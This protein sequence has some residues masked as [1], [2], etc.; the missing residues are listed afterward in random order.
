ME[1][2][3]I[4]SGLSGAV[5]ANKF[6]KKG[7]KVLVLEKRNHIAG[8]VYDKKISGVT[9]HMY[10]PHIFHTNN[11]EVNT[12]MKQFWTLNDFKNKVEGMVQDMI[13]PIPFNFTGVERFFIEEAE[14]IKAKLIDKY[15][16][17]NRVTIFELLSNNDEQLKKVANFVYKNIFE[18]YTTK[19]WG[20]HPNDIDQSV[21]KR[22]PIITG[23]GTRYF[24][25]KYEGVPTEGYTSAVQK[26]LDHKN[27][28]VKLNTNAVD[29][30]ELKDGKVFIDNVEIKCPII[31]TG[32]LDELFNFEY[33]EL[34]Y[35]S[36]KI[37]FEEEPVKK[38][39]STAVVNYPAH[40]KMT[41]ITE[42][43]NMTFEET[44][45]TIISKE[46]PGEYSR[47]SKDF[48]IPYYPMANDESRKQYDKYLKKLNEFKNIYPLGRLARYKYLN[49][50]QI[51]YDSLELTK[52]LLD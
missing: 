50:D 34:S 21:L 13:V 38:F 44:E 29:I 43:K 4:G 12:Y 33:G 52:Q 1:L 27:I 28:E 30:L 6:A 23:Y 36:L 2:L 14:E 32:A 25:D 49:M 46:Y 16:E 15:G 39:Q 51:V 5:I 45:T 26:M 47:E 10:G 31:Y 37:D 9:T 42:Y 41:R 19:M 40:P 18:N 22:V 8:N 7:K 17:N 35:R 11:E 20:V 48:N 3:V 24:S